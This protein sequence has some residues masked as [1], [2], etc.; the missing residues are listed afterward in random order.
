MFKLGIFTGKV[1]DDVKRVLSWI[2]I[3]DFRLIL[4]IRLSLAVKIAN[5]FI[6]L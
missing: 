3:G 5:S 2:G 1:S 4:N 6:N